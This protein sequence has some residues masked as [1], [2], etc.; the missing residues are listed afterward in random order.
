MKKQKKRPMTLLEVMIVIFIIGIIGSVIGYNMRGSMDQG[1]AFKTKEGITKLYNIV[2]LE[3]DSNEIKALEGASSEEIAKK[4]G[5]VLTDSGLVNKPQQYL[6]DGWKNKL[7]FEVVPVKG[8]Y[9]I[10]ANS[11]KYKKFY[12]KKN[13]NPE[14]PWDEE[15][16]DDS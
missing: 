6:I 14:Y 2:H 5:I 9:E 11:E 8:G 16:A 12:E 7:E 1:K 10:R 4:I 15:N 3:M 13:K